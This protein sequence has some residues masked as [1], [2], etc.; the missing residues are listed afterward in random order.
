MSGLICGHER[1]VLRWAIAQCE[2]RIDCDTLMGRMLITYAWATPK[3]DQALSAVLDPAKLAEMLTERG[4]EL[5]VRCAFEPRWFAPVAVVVRVNEFL[6]RPLSMPQ[7]RAI[8]RAWLDLGDGAREE[9]KKALR[10][11]A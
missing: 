2:G 11:G 4:R 8:L 1:E 9:A 10:G 7:A 6:W 5:G 3:Q